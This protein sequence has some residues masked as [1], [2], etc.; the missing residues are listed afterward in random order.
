MTEMDELDEIE[1]SMFGGALEWIYIPSF[2][3]HLTGSMLDMFTGWI[4]C[5]YGVDED[6][7][8]LEFIN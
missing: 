5:T 1:Y 3:L 6:E 2:L 7:Y 4:Q 8:S